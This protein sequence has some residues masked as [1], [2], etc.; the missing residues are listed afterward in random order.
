MFAARNTPTAR[1]FLRAWADML[2]DPEK[3][4][5]SDPAHRG[6]DDQMVGPLTSSMHLEGTAA[7]PRPACC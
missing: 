2:T 7:A 1:A 3:E 6:I 5:H 4:R